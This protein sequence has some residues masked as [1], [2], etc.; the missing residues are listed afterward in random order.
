MNIPYYYKPFGYLYVII[1]K[2]TLLPWPTHTAAIAWEIYPQLDIVSNFTAFHQTP[3]RLSSLNT[4]L[5]TPQLSYS[6]LENLN[7]QIQCY[8]RLIPLLGIQGATKTYVSQVADCQDTSELGRFSHTN[9]LNPFLTFLCILSFPINV[10][11]LYHVGSRTS[12][13]PSKKEDTQF[14]GVGRNLSSHI[15]LAKNKNVNTN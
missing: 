3:K 12:P 7:F 2:L 13:S 14:L 5:G 9:N 10:P 1:G 8:Q 4:Q 15:I 6:L 11:W